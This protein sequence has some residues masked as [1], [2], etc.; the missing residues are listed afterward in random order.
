MFNFLK[1]QF[2]KIYNHVTS[3]LQSL[4]GHKHVDEGLLQDLERILLEADTGVS[5]TRMLMA[6]VRD[7]FLKGTVST[8]SQLKE[9]LGR[10]L[11]E[12][13]AQNA[14]SDSGPVYLLVGVNG[15]G[16][17]TF[18]AKL[19]YFYKKQGKRVL[20]AGADTFRAAAT[21]QLKVWAEKIG[22]D[23]VTGA[24]GKDPAAVVFAACQRF[25]AEGYE[26]LIID[27]AGRLQNKVHLM[28]ELEKVRKVITKHL[29]DTPV[30]TLLTIDS[31]LGQNSF[32]QAKMFNE[33]AHLKG[34]V[35]TKMDGTGK[36]G[37]VFG[38]THELKVPV[39][40]ISYGEKIDQMMPFDPQAYVNQLLDKT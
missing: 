13:L 27:T 38:I 11:K 5:T 34:I 2:T 28:N 18:A 1:D 26:I 31:L 19:A 4:F 29:G 37:I 7:L 15:T 10:E 20:L 33:A 35:L 9:A 8:G 22:V 21:E 14:Y 36:G 40:Y 30:I 23:C 24:E 17:T 3:R 6:H 12:L 39:A 16:K 25:I 32:D